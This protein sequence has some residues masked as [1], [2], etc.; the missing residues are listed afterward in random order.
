MIMAGPEDPVVRRY[1]KNPILTEHDVLYPVE[2]V[3]NAT[4][5]WLR[6]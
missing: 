2:T 3:Y 5:V 6:E 4:S 1:E